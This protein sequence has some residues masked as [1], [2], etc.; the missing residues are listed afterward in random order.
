MA[1]ERSSFFNLNY[2]WYCER[3]DSYQ[4]ILLNKLN[5]YPLQVDFNMEAGMVGFLRGA[6]GPPMRGKDSNK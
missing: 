1:P 3:E 4:G 2:S 5:N 6:A